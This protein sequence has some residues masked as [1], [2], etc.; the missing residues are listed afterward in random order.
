[1][2]DVD[3]MQNMTWTCLTRLALSLVRFFSKLGSAGTYNRSVAAT[4]QHSMSSSVLLPTENKSQYNI[5]IYIYI[6]SLLVCVCVGIWNSLVRSSMETSIF[7]YELL[8]QNEWSQNWLKYIS[9]SF[10]RCCQ[11]SAVLIKGQLEGWN[12]YKRTNFQIA[13]G[14]YETRSKTW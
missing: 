6:Y 3:Q 13:S 5:Y 8:G 14:T 1:M 10:E 7:P 2:L 11:S 9:E 12:I 4:T